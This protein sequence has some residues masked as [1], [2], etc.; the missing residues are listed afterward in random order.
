MVK[1][2]FLFQHPKFLE[3]RNVLID[4]DYSFQKNHLLLEPIEL[5]IFND[6]QLIMSGNRILVKYE[7]GFNYKKVP[8][9]GILLDI[10][11]SI[12]FKQP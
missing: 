1:R 7:H 8:V 6:I 11:D 3:R 4:M 5:S 10:T 12:L 2:F 9:P